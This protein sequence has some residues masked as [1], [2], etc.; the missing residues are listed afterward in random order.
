[1][2]GFIIIVPRPVDIEN[3]TV[4]IPRKENTTKSEEPIEVWPLVEAAFDSI[5]ADPTTREAAREAMEVSDGC[6]TLANFLLSKEEDVPKMDLRFK[7]PV[8]V[9]AAKLGRED[10]GA[11][12]IYDPEEGMLYVE[13]EDHPFAFPV[14]EEW[15]VDWTEV[16]DRVEEN[17]YW[18]GEETAVW[19]LDWLMAYLDIPSD[20]YMVDNQDEDDDQRYSRI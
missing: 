16:A 15:T 13:T 17:Y 5:D 4:A 20:D 2:A 18:D 3:E 7:V 14:Y 1:M 10:D 9:R 8:L 11:E 6:A 12:T 19:A